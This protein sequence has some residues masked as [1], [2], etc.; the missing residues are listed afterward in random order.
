LS[1]AVPRKDG[2]IWLRAKSLYFSPW[3]LRL[4][5]GLLA[6][7]AMLPTLAF[8]ALEYR[9][10][11]NGKK[12]EMERAGH[13]FVTGVSRDVDREISV[14]RAQLST[15]ATS[16]RLQARDYAG[17]YLQ[18][19]ESANFV[20]GW[21]ALFAADGRQIFNTLKPFGSELPRSN[22]TEIAARVAATGQPETTDL[23]EGSVSNRLIVALFYPAIDDLVIVGVIPSDF[24]SGMLRRE[25]PDGWLA[26]LVDRRGVIVARSRG[27]DEYIGKPTTADIRQH[28]AAASQGWVTSNTLDGVE[29]YAGWQRLPNGWTVVAGVPREL[30]EG[31]LRE[32]RSNVL[33]SLVVFSGLALMSSA[34]FAGWITRSMKDLEKAVASI[35]AGE[36]IKPVSTGIRE[37]DDLGRALT[38]AAHDRHRG[39]IANAFLAALVGSSGDAIISASLD[40]KILTWNAAAE[41]LYGFPAAEAIGQPI[42]IFL[43]KDR[44]HELDE[45]MTAAHEGRGIRRETVRRRKDGTLVDISLDLAPIR[46]TD[47]R[48]IGF[49]KIAH[50]ITRRKRDEAHI[51]FVMRELSH[52]TKNLIT[53]IIA[54]VRQT[55]RQS[56]DFTDFEA[57]FTGRLHGLARSHDLLV[58]SDWKGASIDELVRLQLIPFVAD[59]ASLDVNGPALVLKPEAVQNL[60]FALHELATNAHKY[61]ALS[62]PGGKVSIAWRVTEKAPGDHFIHL[63]WRESGGPAV[64]QPYRRGFGSTVIHQLTEAALGA[65]VKSS[66]NPEGFT[67][68]VEMP[69]REILHQSV[70]SPSLI[71]TSLV[72]HEEA[73]D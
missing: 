9:V 50:D 7:G 36:L 39:E 33:W 65:K 46:A 20:P 29:A 64:K 37:V 26:A 68:E 13:A 22:F 71:P 47:G 56:A 19:R 57:K 14:K 25:T 52:R 42:T 61:G 69:A 41:Q 23:F 55:W 62:Q 60:G 28:I 30:I 67:W 17:F 1:A 4:A 3:P 6:L 11:L 10:A 2:S 43:P 53:V 18:A 73:G 66:F 63:A 34:L 54:M 51:E 45:D 5:L 70:G 44:L 58:Y 40:G 21:I 35:G 32:W 24:L 27:A 59:P 16:D 38:K 8:F 49:S 48:V 15:L 12:T 72:Q 31:P